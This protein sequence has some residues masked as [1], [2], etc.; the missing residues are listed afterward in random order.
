MTGTHD[1]DT[2]GCLRFVDKRTFNFDQAGGA[3]N[4]IESH[5]HSYYSDLKMIR[6]HC[7]LSVSEMSHFEIH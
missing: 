5:F 7:K 2:I 6:F 1:F 3:A 4:S